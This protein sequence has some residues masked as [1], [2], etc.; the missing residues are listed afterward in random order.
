MIA[1]TKT[2]VFSQG[3]F[4]TTFS[5]IRLV[6]F[7]QDFTATFRTV[8][9]GN[10]KS[11]RSTFRRY[12]AATNGIRRSPMVVHAHS[13]TPHNKKLRNFGFSVEGTDLQQLGQ[14]IGSVEDPHT[15]IGYR[16]E[17]FSSPFIHQM[18]R[19]QYQGTVQTCLVRGSGCCYRHHG[20]TCTHFGINN[21]CRFVLYHQLL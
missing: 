3:I 12:P 15:G 7:I 8:I 21:G 16:F 19:T 5:V 20:L 17:D 9:L 18:R 2:T 14:C 4:Q 6:F 1:F 13:N 11:L 10:G